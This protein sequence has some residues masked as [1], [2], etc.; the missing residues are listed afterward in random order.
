MPITAIVCLFWGKQ[1]LDRKGA[2][3]FLAVFIGVQSVFWADVIQADV[4]SISGPPSQSVDTSIDKLDAQHNNEQPEPQ[5]NDKH[6]TAQDKTDQ[7]V[8]Q[9]NSKNEFP[10]GLS[11]N[12][13]K[14]QATVKAQSSVG[15]QS[16]VGVQAGT[17]AQSS[18]EV[19]PDTK[20]KSSTKP[21]LNSTSFFITTSGS[22]SILGELMTQER[23]MGSLGYHLNF[24]VRKK[25]LDL[26]IRA[27]HDFWP[28]DEG[29]TS[30][31]LQ[32][33]NVGLGGGVRYFSGG[34][35]TSLTIGPSVL[36]TRSQTDTPGTTGL[37]LDFRPTGLRFVL[38]P[39]ATFELHFLTFNV[40]VPVF[41]SLPLVY[42]SFRTVLCVEF[43]FGRAN[44]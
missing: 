43:G 25:S 13:A 17:G 27:E 20:N 6:A 19:Q 33:F 23:I 34:V 5:G 8:I 42:L 4:D 29:E 22:I 37:F 15:A 30:L 36:L 16:G 38:S 14:T 35:R 10:T 18:T 11:K 12:G 9:D 7:K 41:S 26:F 3:A 24:G 21:D 31:S 40:V 44:R 32:T 39:D 1:R 2:N 28:D